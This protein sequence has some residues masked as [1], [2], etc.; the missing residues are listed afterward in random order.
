[1]MLIKKF[2]EEILFVRKP[3]INRWINE[4]NKFELYTNI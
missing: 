1:M 3:Q 2:Y 4:N